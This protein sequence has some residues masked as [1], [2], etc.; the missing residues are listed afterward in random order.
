MASRIMDGVIETP[1]RS[2]IDLTMDDAHDGETP[3]PASLCDYLPLVGRTDSVS[4]PSQAL[5][6]EPGELTSTVALFSAPTKTT[7][8]IT[9]LRLP[10]SSS[11]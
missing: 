5:R 11:L 2:I 3:P 6:E 7:Q 4:S 8:P 1:P 10:V 9:T